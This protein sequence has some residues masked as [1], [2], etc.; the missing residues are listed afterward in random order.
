M[1]Q[2]QTVRDITHVNYPFGFYTPGRSSVYARCEDG[3]VRRA[4]VTSATAD[5][6]FSI[7]ARV[8]VR[9]E[10]GH[11]RSVSGFLSPDSTVH[12]DGAIRF[13]AY[14]YGKNHALINKDA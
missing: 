12:G 3:V 5:T 7:P 8:R 13:I 1:P 11:R 4:T 6:F 14:R 9:D 2:A 10:Q